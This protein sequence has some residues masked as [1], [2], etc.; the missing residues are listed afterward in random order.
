MNRNSICSLIVKRYYKKKMF[1]SLQNM[2]TNISKLNYFIELRNKKVPLGIDKNDWVNNSFDELSKMLF[3]K[4]LLQE[5]NNFIK[6]YSK[7]YYLTNITSKKFLSIWL[8]LAFPEFIIDT[9]LEDINTINQDY[10]TDLFVITRELHNLLINLSGDSENMRKFNKQMN[11]YINA[12]D[13]Y[14]VLNKKEKVSN[15]IREWLELEKSIQLINI[16]NKYNTDEKTKS[17][18]IIENSRK[19]VEKYIN[20]FITVPDDFYIKLKDV[21]V[22]KINLEN[23]LKQKMDNMLKEELE[24]NNFNNLINILEQIKSFILTFTKITEEQ[25]Q[26]QIDI[27]YI[28]QLIEHDVLTIKEIDNFGYNLLSNICSAGSISLQEVQLKEWEKTVVDYNSDYKLVIGKLLRLSIETISLI[29]EEIACFRE[30]LE[31]VS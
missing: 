11:I 9:K 18:L 22:Q 27:H 10:K 13:V 21:V 23:T 17:I 29:I 2:Q 7:Y 14:L 16:S 4:N 8:I 31:L 15:Y 3:N 19:L 24:D 28:V 12:L 5:V 30:Y 1:I 26:E 25:I 20:K 6:T